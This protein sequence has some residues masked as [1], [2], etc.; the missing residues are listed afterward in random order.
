ML[1]FEQFTYGPQA[2]TAFA[3]GP[4]SAE[5]QGS[6]IVQCIEYMRDNKYSTIN[7]TREAEEAWRVHT[8]EVADKSLFPQANSWYFGK[9]VPGKAV[10]ALNYMGGL[11]LYREKCW[12]SAN[13]DYQGFVLAH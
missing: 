4:N 8:N 5:T 1:I 11:P 6:W 7:A 12:G 3:T 13:N 2:P 9:N 10:E